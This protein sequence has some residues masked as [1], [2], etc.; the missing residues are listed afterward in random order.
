MNSSNDIAAIQTVRKLLEAV[1]DSQD[2]DVELEVC[3]I[4]VG[5]S[6]IVDGVWAATEDETDRLELQLRELGSAWKH[7]RVDVELA[8]PADDA[9]HELLLVI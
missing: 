6:L 1:A 9:I 8:E 4:D 5:R 3:G 2:W 7:L